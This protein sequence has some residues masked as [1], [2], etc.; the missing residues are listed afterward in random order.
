MSPEIDISNW[1]TSKVTDMRYMFGFTTSSSTPPTTRETP[2]TTIKG[3]LD[4]SSCT[5][6]D[7]MFGETPNLTGVQIKNPAFDPTNAE[8]KAAFEETS[9]ITASQYTIVA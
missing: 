6:Y 1:D 5:K 4:M 7:Y 9:K 2:L 8:E 3:V